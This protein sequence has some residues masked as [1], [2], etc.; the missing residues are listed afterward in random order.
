MTLATV[1]RDRLHAAGFTPSD[2]IGTNGL[3]GR[4]D[5][6]GLNLAQFPA[7]LVELGNMKN[8]GEAST[9]QTPE[10]RQRYAAAVVDGRGS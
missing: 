6:A 2:Y 7:V 9:M 1:M 8:P 10:G 5:M 4:A 3:Y